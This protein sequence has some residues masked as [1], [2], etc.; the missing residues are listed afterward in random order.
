MADFNGLTLNNSKNKNAKQTKHMKRIDKRKIILTIAIIAGGLYHTQI[1]AQTKNNLSRSHNESVNIYGTF[2]PV[3]GEA[4]KLNFKP[5]NFVPHIEQSTFDIEPAVSTLPTD[6]MLKPVKPATLRI[7]KRTKSYENYLIA[8]LGS[9]I[10]PYA[11]YFH[12]SGKR[13][14][15]KLDFH[16]F[17]LSSFK[18]IDDYLPSPFTST[19]AQLGVEKYFRYHSLGINGS[20]GF[21]TNRY[22]G[23]KPSDFPGTNIDQNHPNLKQAYNSAR[24]EIEL[25]SRYKNND[26]IAHT[27]KLGSYYYFDKYGTAEINADMKFDAH[28]AFSVSDLLDYQR[29]GAEGAFQFYRNS[30]SLNAGTND[31]YARFMPYFGF[32]YDFVSFKT[33]LDFALQ[34]SDS[35]K[36]HF[37]PYLHASLNL[38]PEVVTVFAGIDGGLQKNSYKKL[39]KENPFLSS[40]PG[41][42][43]WTNNKI[44]LFAGIKG[45]V[46]GRFGFY[47][48]YTYNKFDNMAFFDYDALPFAPVV[49]WYKNEFVVSYSSGSSN[50]FEAGLNYREGETIKVW[51]NGFFNSYNLDNGAIA[52]FKP[53]I[54]VNFGAEVSINDKIKPY[55]ELWYT[56]QRD[57]AVKNSGGPTLNSITLDPYLDLNTGIKY[58]ITDRLS[59]FLEITNLLNKKYMLFTDYPVGGI[60]VMGGVTYR[61]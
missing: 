33:G 26:K 12:S 3:I 43:L 50:I 48:K 25:K 15:Y 57:G 11:E 59:I 30:D 16:L 18:N 10:T 49:P 9:R 55:I 22:Y 34:D 14:S 19:A 1:K 23:F 7:G 32:K 28:K 2:N 37:Y 47:F 35:L 24:L 4:Y 13:N 46:A 29:L 42:F 51:L 41:K 38:V 40:I 52:Y 45:S 17:H 27:V 44:N 21:N 5:G 31:I 6:I 60:Q 58:A 54:K 61:F 39:T 56:G 8:G 20:Y 36:F 53:K